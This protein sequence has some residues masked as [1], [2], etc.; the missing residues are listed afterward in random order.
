MKCDNRVERNLNDS[1]EW[2]NE[3]QFLFITAQFDVFALKKTMH[4]NACHVQCYK[5]FVLSIL[6][7][8]HFARAKQEHTEPIQ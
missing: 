1:Y 5:E 8:I 3:S 2:F 7:F 4:A 6:P